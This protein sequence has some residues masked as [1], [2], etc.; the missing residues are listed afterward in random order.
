MNKLYLK[1]LVKKEQ[2]KI[3]VVASTSVID[4]QGESIDQSGWD[5]TNFLKNPVMLWAHN[6]DELPLGVWENIRVS[7]GLLKMD[8]N[9]ASKEANPKAENVRLLVEEGVEKTVSVG[10]IPKE[11]DGHIITK[12]ELLEVS[13]VPVPANP[14]ALALAISKGYNPEIMKTEDVF[15]VDCG[16]K[17]GE[18]NQNERKTE[19]ENVV[20]LVCNNCIKEKSK[21]KNVCDP[22][23][24]DY[25]QEECDEMMKQEETAVQTVILSKE[26]FPTEAD[27][28]EWITAH[29]FHAEKVDETEDS[30]R[31]RQFEPSE[32]QEGSFRTID[33]TDGVK[34]VICRPSDGKTCSAPRVRLGKNLIN[35]K[36]GRVIS[37][38]NRGL[39]KDAI[40]QFEN[41]ISVLQELLKATDAPEKGGIVITLG[42]GGKVNDLGSDEKNG[43]VELSAELLKALL[44]HSRQTDKANE[45]VLRMIKSAL[46]N[47][48]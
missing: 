21:I 14:E 6:Y 19:Q 5:L 43:Q 46:K 17:L 22:D 7:D 48:K 12:A 33:L 37:E 30:W 20:E 47:D 27:A 42:E 44:A 9:F 13:F 45:L 2:D 35:E 31:F 24:E 10:F 25:D 11:R 29:D 41:S 3:T 16:A 1:A 38:K 4:R 8:A 39:I 32:C 34:A 36:V 40:T 18:G 23:S 15:C 28:R 26:N